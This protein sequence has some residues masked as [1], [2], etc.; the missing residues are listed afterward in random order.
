MSCL[1][2]VDPGSIEKHV[3]PDSFLV[4]NVTTRAACASSTHS[5]RCYGKTTRPTQ[6]VFIMKINTATPIWN[7][8]PAASSAKN[9]HGD[10]SDHYWKK[11]YVV[12]PSLFHEI[13]V[14]REGE[15]QFIDTDH[16]LDRVVVVPSSNMAIGNPRVMS[17]I[18][19][20]KTP[21]KHTKSYGTW[22]IHVIYS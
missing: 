6:N 2:R 20:F 5:E 16:P 3:A 12:H 9:E 18:F 19:L 7:G 17:R 22:T 14:G 13:L 11:K 4:G 21:G 8:K 10:F 1:R 15:S